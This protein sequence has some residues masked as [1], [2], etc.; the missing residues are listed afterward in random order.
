MRF[1]DNPIAG[2]DFAARKWFANN[3]FGVGAGGSFNA[4]KAIRECGLPALKLTIRPFFV[5]PLPSIM[6]FGGSRGAKE[7]WGADAE[8]AG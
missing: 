1:S 4:D 7:H 2:V 5:Y 3:P 6:P 8:G